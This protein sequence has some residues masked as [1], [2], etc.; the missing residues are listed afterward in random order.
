MS[1]FYAQIKATEHFQCTF[2]G[3]WAWG[4]PSGG[5]RRSSCILTVRDLCYLPNAAG[6]LLLLTPDPCQEMRADCWSPQH[7][8]QAA[9]QKETKVMFH[10]YGE[11]REK[12]NPRSSCT[13][14]HSCIQPRTP[15]L[16]TFC[17]PPAKC[18]RGLT[19]TWTLT[20]SSEASSLSTKVEPSG[21]RSV[22]SR[23]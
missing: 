10:L 23:H 21:G 16:A 17:K 8:S 13:S 20:L 2:G 19:H 9:S 1:L 11:K 14:W 3:G 18:H 5:C 12:E 15:S 22:E 7:C 4:Q 6:S